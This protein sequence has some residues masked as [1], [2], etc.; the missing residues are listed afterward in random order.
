MNARHGLESASENGR[1]PHALF[2]WKGQDVKPPRHSKL[3]E[4]LGSETSILESVIREGQRCNMCYRTISQ[5]IIFVHKEF[6][7]VKVLLERWSPRN[8]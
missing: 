8:D 7:S 1:V 6:G 3:M 2:K 4:E 5:L